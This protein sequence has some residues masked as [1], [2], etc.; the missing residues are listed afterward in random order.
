MDISQQLTA[1]SSKI[2]RIEAQLN[3]LK[4][5]NQRLVSE[6]EHL[7]AMLSLQAEEIASLHQQLENTPLR[8]G[9]TTNVSL[10]P[11]NDIRQQ[12]DGYL[13]EIDK[14]IKRLEQQ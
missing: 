10:L 3:Q 5:D 1:I 9:E 7:Q 14:C 4:L 8:Q 12:I 2:Y 13:R 11:A 6:N